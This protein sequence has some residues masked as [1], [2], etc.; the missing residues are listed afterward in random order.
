MLRGK[1]QTASEKDQIASISERKEE[2]GSLLDE[3][4]FAWQG[5][6]N[7]EKVEIWCARKR[8]QMTYIRGR[9]WRVYFEEGSVDG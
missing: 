3:R 4:R 9:K 8:E 7:L 6:P 2:N 5:G 1:N